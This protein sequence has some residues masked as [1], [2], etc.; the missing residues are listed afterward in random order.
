MSNRLLVRITHD[1]L[2]QVKDRYPF[3]YLEHGRLEIDDSAVKWIDANCSVVRIP[4]ATIATILIGPGTSVTHEAIKVLSAANTTLCWV[5]E[6]SLLYYATG[7]SPTSDSRGIRRQIELYSDP[8]N[9]LQV[10]KRMFSYRFP[11]VDISDSTLPDLMGKEGLRIKR[12]YEEF[13]RKYNVGWK[14]RCYTPGNFELSDI[15]NKILTS[16]NAILYA[17][18]VSIV[19]SMGYSPHIGYIHSGSPLPF[20]YD[21]A[22]LY[23]EKLTIE[24][25]F[26]QTLRMAGE[27]DRY[28]LLEQ[29]RKSVIEY[30]LLAKVPNDLKKILES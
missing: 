18:I 16:A 30:D 29:F 24:F 1:N 20:I 5:G 17:L 6:D 13:A 28:E 11:D 27:Y 19:V 15:T 22:D 25:A 8:F 23:K 3:I 4:I 21:I 12:L 2:P 7:I 14:G 9:R 26:K 10:A